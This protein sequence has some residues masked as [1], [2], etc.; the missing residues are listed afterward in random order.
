M[1]GDIEAVT[2]R[3]QAWVEALLAGDIAK[4]ETLLSPCFLL[5]GVRS[6]GTEPIGRDVWFATLGAMR[7]HAMA[8]KGVEVSLFGDCALASVYGEW[9]VDFHGRRIDERFLLTDVWMREAVGWR[10]VRRHSS[11]YPKTAG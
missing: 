7:F 1:T 5:V 2:A 10:A 9:T 4:L 6:T 11:P 8:L 3:E